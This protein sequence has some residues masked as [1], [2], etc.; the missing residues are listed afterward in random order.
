MITQDELTAMQERARA[1]MKRGQSP[2]QQL[3]A[4]ILREPP[5]PG[6]NVRREKPDE[7][8]QTG[9][10][11]RMAAYLERELAEGRI[12]R[13]VYEGIR[14]RYATSL[15]YLPDFFVERPAGKMLLVETKG[16]KIF[17]RDLVRFKACREEWQDIFDFEMWRSTAKD[18]ERIL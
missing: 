10:E 15:H 4:R 18:F 12:K 17:E 8:K 5:R 11:R 1:G 7:E 9:A 16:S 6:H 2:I 3:A 14:L 13:F